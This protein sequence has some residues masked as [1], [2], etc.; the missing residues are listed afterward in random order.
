MTLLALERVGKRYRAGRR[1]RVVLDEVSLSLEQGELVAIWGM[2]RSGRSTLLRI[3][4]G[5]EPPDT[6]F[7]RF[8]GRDL[9]TPGRQVLGEGIGYCRPAPR[10]R[11]AGVVLDELMLGPRARGATQSAA[12]ASA[13]AALAR[14]GASDCAEHPINELDG[15]EAVRVSIARALLLDPAVLIIDEPVTG[16]DLL[17][18]DG[19]LTLLRSLADDGLA[20]AG[21]GALTRGIAV[22]MTVGESTALAGC[23]RALRIGGGGLGGN[24]EPELATVVP[25]L[26]EASA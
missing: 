6:G 3:A 2:P 1:E 5:I 7:V 14:V 9:N 20:R 10:D 22:L 17:H 25:I 18:R 8:E 23:D 19:L 4:A 24:T 13:H 15:A 16:V 11:E 26:R 12:A 21:G